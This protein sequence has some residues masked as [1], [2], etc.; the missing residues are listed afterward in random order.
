MGAKHRTYAI[1]TYTQKV[2]LREYIKVYSESD[3]GR[4]RSAKALDICI[5]IC[6][7]CFS[8]KGREKRMGATMYRMVAFPMVLHVAPENK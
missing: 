2:I 3:Y 7:V 6:N 4:R 1:Y 8:E 5:C